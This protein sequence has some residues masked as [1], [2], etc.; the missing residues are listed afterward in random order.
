[1]IKYL[2][3]K[4]AL[5][6][7]LTG[8]IDLFPELHSVSDL[9]SGTSR[10]GHAFKRLG[11][12]VIAS[13]YNAYAHTLA[14]CYVA[15]DRERYE[16][17]ANALIEE[18]NLVS[19]TP[20]YFTETF[21]QKS[22]FFQPFNGERVDAIRERIAD[23]SVG[24]HLR[25]ILLTSLM[26]AADRVDSTCG[27]QMSYVKRWAKRSYRPLSLR[28]PD[29]APAVQ[30][31]SCEA[32][33]LD[34]AEAARLPVDIAYLDPPYNQHSYLSNY[35][36]WESLVRWDKPDVYGVACKR[37]DCRERKSPYNS[38]RSC[39]D[40]LTTL[41][42]R[43]DAPLIITSFN[44]EGFIDR[45]TLIKT[46][47]TRGDVSVFEIPFKRYVG[48]KIG[49]HNQRGQRVGEVSHTHN[50]EYIFVVCT[51]ELDLRVPD[52]RARFRRFAQEHSG[53]VMYD[54]SCGG[55]HEKRAESTS[56]GS[57]SPS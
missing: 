40:A 31:G 38:K 4:R 25:A 34:A 39:L 7:Y 55:S 51:P 5:L 18:L 37:V 45:A 14:Q 2:G 6:H 35:H 10:C 9:F 11:R 28:L 22:R 16:R 24:P 50:R 41:I 33:L 52:A 47:S 57:Y 12:R 15:S 29:L 46:L 20:G 8:L 36:I 19:G 27:I 32:H 26:E 43:V 42:E 17:D 1:M 23:L 56:K 13:D 48:A 53:S 44:D 49:I 3:S 21:C 30:W 54:D